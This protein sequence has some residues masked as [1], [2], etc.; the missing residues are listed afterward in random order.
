MT[1][2]A[3]SPAWLLLPL[4]APLACWPSALATETDENAPVDLLADPASEIEE[5]R[6]ARAAELEAIRRSIEVSERRQE[7]LNDEIQGLEA[8]EAELTAELIATAQRMRAAE[9]EIARTESRLTELHTSEDT[10]RISLRERRDVMAELLM[11][12]QRMGRTPPPAL[13]SRPEDALA[14]I[15]GSILAG[16]VLPDLREDAEQLADDL[17][18]LAGLTDQIEIEREALRASYTALGE[19]Q[20]RIDLLVESKQAQRGQT[21]E[22]LTAEQGRA[23]ELAEQA[24]SVEGLIASIEQEAARAASAAEQQT[25]A[26]EVQET[27]ASQTA[28]QIDSARIAPAMRFAEAKGRLTLPVAGEIVRGFGEL[29]ELGDEAQGLSIAARPGS[30][31]L[32]PADGWVVYAGPFRSYGQVLILDAGDGYHIVMAGMERIDV[33]LRQFVLAGEPVAVMG[34]TRLASIGE[35]DHTSALLPLLYVE[36]RK[37]G[38][39]ID[40]ASWWAASTDGEVNG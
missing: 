24:E 39:A 12:L 28:E 9:D 17:A 16:A 34:A 6:Q 32:A 23:A 40:S 37:D 5:R 25:T 7:V 2:R 8:D 20:A 29:D 3:R 1:I 13:L 26:A 18:V 11:A 27:A 30:P 15:R 22:A 21:E 4:L 31:V 38:A 14:A 35:I 36:L 19:E 10:L 33:A